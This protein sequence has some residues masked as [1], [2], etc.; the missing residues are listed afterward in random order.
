MLKRILAVLILAPVFLLLGGCP[1][2][3]DCD[4]D[5]DSDGGSEPAIFS[6][7]LSSTA[8]ENVEQIVLEIDSVTLRRSDAEDIVIETFTLVDSNTVDEETFQIDLLDNRGLKQRVVIDDL[9]ID[10]GTYSELVLQ[11]VDGNINNSFVEE[12]NGEMAALNVP[13]SQLSFSGFRLSA[14]NE[15]LTIEFNLGLSLQTINSDGS[16][17]LTGK[18]A[19][20]V[21]ND[22][23]SSI[24]GTVDSSLFDTESPCE[25]KEDPLRG[26]L[27]YLYTGHNLSAEALADVF[28]NENENEV[29]DNA[30]A[31][32]SV[33]ALIENESRNTFE[34]AFGFLPE[35]DYTVVFSCNALNDDPVD[36]D[37]IAIPLPTEQLYEVSLAED[38]QFECDFEDDSS[39]ATETP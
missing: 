17:F 32:Y 16:Y 6:L 31:P 1:C 22:V 14:G 30:I 2:G 26:N 34:Y 25:G 11:V 8:I 20:V 37:D 10:S 13:S 9:E 27:V 39:C 28:T 12:T 4:R 23:D 33:S 36:F 7:G 24:S 5:D 21:D 19:R 35:N 18:G 15:Q 38:E 29:G 3:F